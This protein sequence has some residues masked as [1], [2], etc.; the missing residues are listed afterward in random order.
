MQSMEFHEE[1]EIPKK[2]KIS[3][4]PRQEI[5]TCNCVI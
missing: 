2:T 3:Q 1:I 4:N 5:H